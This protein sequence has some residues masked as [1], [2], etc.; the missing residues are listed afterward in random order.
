VADY[1]YVLVRA[2]D[3]QLCGIITATD[4]TEQF[5]KLAE[6][7][8]LWPVKLKMEFGECFTDVS[9]KKSYAPQRLQKNRRTAVLKSPASTRRPTL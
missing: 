1:A 5:Q 8:L 3:K 9:Q 6:P 4:L 2:G 7:F